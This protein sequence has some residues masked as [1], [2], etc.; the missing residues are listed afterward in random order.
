MRVTI[1]EIY[2]RN[3]GRGEEREDDTEY[4]VHSTND[5]HYQL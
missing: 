4:S 3:L 5:L 2:E 1:E